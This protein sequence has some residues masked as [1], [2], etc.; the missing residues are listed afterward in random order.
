MF[1]TK[2]HVS[3]RAVLRGAVG[4]AVGLP[5]LDAMVPAASAQPAPQF[6]FGAIYVPNG[7]R[8]EIWTPARSKKLE[9]PPLLVRFEPLREHINIVTGLNAAPQSEHHSATSLWL[10]GGSVHKT[11]GPDV[12]SAKTI[13][14][15]VADAM[16]RDTAL[17]SLE[18]GIE[19]MSGSPGSCAFGFSC[20]YMNTLSWRTPTAP[21]PMELNPQTVFERLFGDSGTPEQRA[22]RWSEKSSLLD[23]VLVAAQGLQKDMGPQ[24]RATIDEYLENIREVERRIQL[25]GRQL[26]SDVDLPTAPT[27]IPASYEEH[28]RL[29]YDLVALAFRADV[30][31]VFTFMKGVEASPIN[32]P[33]IG[34]P[35]SHHIVSHHQNNPEAMQKYAKINAYQVGL[36]GDF[37]EKLKA[38]PDGDG[39]LLDHSL[40]MY[41]SAMGN[42]NFHDQTKLPIML[43]GGASGRVKGGRHIAN[44]DPTPI[45]NLIGS[46]GDVA[47]LDLGELER[48]M[49]R[50]DL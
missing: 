6:R 21:L 29:M 45:A 3:R 7:V 47:G 4:A 36:F 2:K 23:S 22:A 1:I 11:E 43:A 42:G 39:S 40:L 16:G 33:Q 35:E 26:E 12:R 10:H 38:T 24:D 8:P 44:P 27:G 32:Y 28:V 25:A 15:H 18:L 48:S 13:D 5:L 17:P 14:Q 31:R 34:V 50:V 37:V 49:G 46:L 19:D 41:G 9:L 20:I 30:T